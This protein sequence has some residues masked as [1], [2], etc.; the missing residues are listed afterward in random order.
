VA[1]KRLVFRAQDF[2][3]SS[4]YKGVPISRLTKAYFAEDDPNSGEDTYNRPMLLKRKRMADDEAI[5]GDYFSTDISSPGGDFLGWIE[6][7]GTTA[8]KLLDAPT[9]KW[10]ELVAS[11]LGLYLATGAL[12]AT[13]ERRS[14]TSLQGASR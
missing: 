1:T 10:I 5:E 2:G 9:I 11:I 4:A 3:E 12:R 14:P 7:G 6:T 8:W 13:D